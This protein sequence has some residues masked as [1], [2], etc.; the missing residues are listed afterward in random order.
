MTRT[1]VLAG[2]PSN[3]RIARDPETGR[4]YRADGNMTY[5][6][7]K[8]SLTPE[9]KT[10]LKYVDKSAGNDIIK[11]KIVETAVSDVHYIGK[12]D[13]NIYQCVTKDIQTDDVIITDE[14]IEHIKE[15][16]PN[17]YERFSEYFEKIIREPDYIIEANK[18]NSALI[19]K[20]IEEVNEQFKT[21]LRL[22]TYSDDSEIKN[23][24]ITFIKIDEKEWNR[25]TRNKK[26]L[27]KPE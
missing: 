24:I 20:H 23:S 12:L 11:S 27:Y 16:H 18:P 4:N 15:H 10:A 22:S 21:V 17:D 14:R 19:L 7:W 9:Q 25:L 26:I 5:S 13:K 2:Y 3:T 1:T 6:E 8:R